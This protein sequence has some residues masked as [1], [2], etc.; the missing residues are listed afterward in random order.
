MTRYRH[1]P[2]NPQ[3]LGSD[4]VHAVHV[5]QQGRL[6]AGT[7][8]GGLN[9]FDP[10]TETFTRYTHR[11]L[12]PNT[13]GDNTI[14]FLY[15]DDAEALWVG[16]DAG[17]AYRL[18]HEKSRFTNYRRDPLDPNSLN[19]SDIWAVF[20]DHA[21]ILWVGTKSGGHHNV[22]YNADEAPTTMHLDPNNPLAPIGEMLKTL[23]RARKPVLVIPHVGGG[24]P[25]KPPIPGA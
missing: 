13:L 6:W 7:D 19:D 17:G 3:S 25:D 8:E 21:G 10:A 11:P 5:D 9:L 2:A 22:L 18:A 15:E 1:D 20:E 14:L 12:D 23:D 4:V 16:T 24:P